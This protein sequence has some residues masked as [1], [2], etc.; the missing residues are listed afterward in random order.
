MS[1]EPNYGQFMELVGNKIIDNWASFGR[2]VGLTHGELGVIRECQDVPFRFSYVLDKWKK[3][4]YREKPFTWAS[5]V[6][7]LHSMEI[8]SVAD[9][10]FETFN[11][12]QEQ[13]PN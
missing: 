2:M 12:F 6:N 3:R 10:V 7:V 9:A 13:E 11:D 4:Y 1:E 8:D 5:V